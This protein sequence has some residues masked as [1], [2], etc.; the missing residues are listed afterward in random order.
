MNE[1]AKND[2][3][4]IINSTTASLTPDFIFQKVSIKDINTF[5]KC[6]EELKNEGKLII[7]KKKKIASSKN[8][9]L[10]PAKIISQS[11]GYAFAKTLEDAKDI[12]IFSE[13]LKLSIVGDTV[14]L[15]NIRE[16]DKGPIGEVERIVS[17]GP[18][19]ITGTINRSHSGCELIPDTNFRY[20]IPVTKGA[21]LGARNND[22]VQAII[23]CT[24]RKPQPRARV[25]KI[26]GKATSAKIC[27]DAIIDANSIPSVFPKEVILEAKRVSNKPIKQEDIINRT[28]L[29]DELIFTID[30]VDAKDLDDAISIKSTEKGWQLGVHI[31]DVSNYVK[32]NSYI[33]KEAILRGTSVYFADRV[34]PMLPTELS[35]GI[36]SLNANEDKLTFSCI[37][38]ID[39]NGNLLSYEFKKTIINSKVRGV[40]SEIN[41]ILNNQASKD[42]LD[43]Y[44]IIMKSIKEA[45]F[46][47]DILIKKS[48]QR[49][50][51]NLESSESKFEL[52]E[53]GVCINISKRQQGTAENMIE[54]FMIMAN[55]SAALYAKSS[56]IPF[57][58]RI[59]ETPDPEK[60]RTLSNL[61]G[62]L[63]INNKRIREGINPSDFKNL[64]TEAQNTPAY[65]IISHQILR[66][67]SK[68]KYSQNP[69]G[70]FGLA[71]KDYCHF[72]SPI[73]RY[74]DTAIH[75][76]L[77]DLVDGISIDKIKKLYND[78][79]TDIS[80]TST[81]CEI[82]AMQAER[83]AEK[84]YMAEYMQKHIGEIYDGVISG[85]VPSG[86]FVELENNIEGFLNL[87]YFP[88]CKFIFDGITS[89]KDELSN[90]KLSIGDKIKIEVVSAYV[91]T[92]SIDFKP[93][94]SN[95]K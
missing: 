89:H 68:A 64:L 75:R 41:D 25:L 32:P 55:Q 45:K 36:C 94:E 8:C 61:C 88:E 80:K 5:V 95:K 40:Y 51:I 62:A 77:S 2:I 13:K 74:P 6:I 16:S 47:A 33:D 66:T 84:C 3:L 9:G 83:D 31:A 34:I 52:D 39:F 42:I 71:L 93:V 58:Y 12:F 29:R 69:I 1:Q 27:A 15:T 30:G 28:D 57:V 43:K 56:L 54:Q 59:H 76:I 81:E 63:G 82:R 53:N 11:K 24:P 65:K 44:S 78:Y 79:V 50:T 19:I 72:T 14:M 46:L 35:N 48:N 4:K 85:V 49:G 73:R 17:K 20:N 38:E 86:I 7:T 70:H 92:G 18:R 10:V 60:L 67:M 90:T 26:Y 87:E 21:T 23:S 37:M 91:P 22:K